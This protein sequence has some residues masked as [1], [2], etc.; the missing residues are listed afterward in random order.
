M[1][2]ICNNVSN[3]LLQEIKSSDEFIDL[4]NNMNE[5]N[6]NYKIKFKLSDLQKNKNFIKLNDTDKNRLLNNFNKLNKS[7]NILF[8]CNNC[9]YIE[10]MENG[11]ILFT[12]SKINNNINLP[13]EKK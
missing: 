7:N 9:N 13:N 3:N 12:S 6:F 1:L 8:F 2:D 5:I 11:K 10:P 4:L